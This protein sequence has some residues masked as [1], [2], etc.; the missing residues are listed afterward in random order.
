MLRVRN[1]IIN[2][3]EVVYIEYQREDKYL[4]IQLKDNDYIGIENFEKDEFETK[5]KYEN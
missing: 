1:Y 4:Y 2:L 3:R 5:F